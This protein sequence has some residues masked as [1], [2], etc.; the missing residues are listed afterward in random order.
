MA[1][2]LHG[3]CQEVIEMP[4]LADLIEGALE[5]TGWGL[6][7]A[8]GAAVAL[9]GA[10]V[11][12]P[13]AKQAIRGYLIAAHRGRELAAEAAEQLQDIYAEARYEYE[14]QLST[15]TGSDKRPRRRRRGPAPVEQPA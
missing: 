14:S 15:E 5:S 2:R 11:A 12:K 7:L 4:G 6:A 9:V 13:L 3:N 1:S 10:P 8:A